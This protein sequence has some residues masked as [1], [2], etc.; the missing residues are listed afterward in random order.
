MWTQNLMEAGNN[1]MFG[2]MRGKFKGFKWEYC[3]RKS[4]LDPIIK[5]K[6]DIGGADR[7][8][9]GDV[10]FIIGFLGFSFYLTARNLVPN[11]FRYIWDYFDKDGRAISGNSMGREYGFEWD[12]HHFGLDWHKSIG[13]SSNRKPNP[14]G[15]HLYWWNIWNWEHMGTQIINEQLEWQDG[16]DWKVKDE[17]SKKWTSPYTYILRDGTKQERV[18]TVKV[19]RMQWGLRGLVKLGIGKLGPMKRM[20]SIWVDFDHSIGEEVGSYKGG[21]TGCGYEMKL[22]ETPLATLR[23][24]ERERKFER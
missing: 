16:S 10:L 3:W 15:W 7:R 11:R 17:C 14:Y 5:F 13:E 19:D 2:W 21:T 9:D 8:D 6:V 1:N 12:A 22:G 4:I 24:M 23:R 20:Q 18:A